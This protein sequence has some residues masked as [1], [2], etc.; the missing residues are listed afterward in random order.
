VIRVCSLANRLNGPFL[1]NYLALERS[2]IKAKLPFYMHVEAQPWLWRRK[3]EWELEL[4]ADHPKDQFVFIDA[5]DYL[6]VGDP[7]ELQAI[8]DRQPLLFS[9]DAGVDPWPFT[10][11]A[12][13]YDKLR[14]RL[15]KW[16]WLNGSGPAGTGEAIADAIRYG[17]LH[18]QIYERETDQIFW[19]NV[20]L[21]GYGELDQACELTQSLY[22]CTNT[23]L[24]TKKGRLHNLQTS[25][26]PQ[27]IHATGRTWP[28]I[29]EKCIPPEEV[30]VP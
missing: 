27:F 21:D 29:P 20:Y 7:D 19:S 4:A 14:P 3:I 25:S 1:N 30:L 26:Q 12:D 16:C 5:F 17:Q 6:F 28:M 2:L 13:F 22:H 8:L 9:T 24:G 10:H 23:D 18:Y 11:Y 15:S